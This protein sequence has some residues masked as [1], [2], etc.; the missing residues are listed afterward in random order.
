LAIAS[1]QCSALNQEGVLGSFAQG[2][3]TGGVQIDL[4]FRKHPGNRIQKSGSVV[5]AH[6]Q[7]PT[8]APAIWNQFN[9]WFNRKKSRAP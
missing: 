1:G 5:S 4:V 8:F 3:D 2:G 6:G 9:G 7:Q